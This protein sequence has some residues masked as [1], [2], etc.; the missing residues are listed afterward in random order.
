MLLSLEHE[1]KIQIFW[2]KILR[3][4]YISVFALIRF[5]FKAAWP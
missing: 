5:S 1:T 3:Y 4:D 2:E